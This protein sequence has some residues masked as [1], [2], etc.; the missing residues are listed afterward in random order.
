VAAALFAAGLAVLAPLVAPATAA[1]AR[2]PATPSAMF[3]KGVLTVHGTASSETI[4][5]SRRGRRATVRVDGRRVA[6]PRTYRNHL[7][8][9]IR[10]LGLAG[11][12]RI[13]I[14]SSRGKLPD[15]VLVGGKG[16]DVLTGGS[17]SDVLDGSQG[18][19]LLRPG[20]GGVKDVLDGG[21]GA[22]TFQ[23]DADLAGGAT[24]NEPDADGPDRLDLAGTAAPLTVYLGG[25][26]TQFVTSVYSITL[27][28]L[29][30][31]NLIGGSGDDHVVGSNR[32]NRI[33]GGPG[34]DIIRPTPMMA[35][36]SPG[37]VLV[38]DAG[39]D[40]FEFFVS[41]YDCGS[42]RIEDSAGSDTVSF[43]G[44]GGSLT[45][46]LDTTVV[47]TIAY[48][49]RLQLA[50]ESAVDN[51]VG[52]GVD[53]IT[54]NDLPNRLNGWYGDD[55]LTGKGGADTF[56]VGGPYPGLG[57]WG[58]D[59]VTDFAGGTDSVDLDSGMSVK[60]GFGTPTVTIWDGTTDEGTITASN[61]HL[62]AAQ[63]FA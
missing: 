21:L 44:S 28:K 22:D 55:T 30:V 63:D 1:P 9:E 40:T 51:V 14:D 24:I 18:D 52:G 6:L 53:D 45:T 16:D 3:A 12:D 7:C 19:D 62:W 2:G 15:I 31:E 23:I 35:L 48:D 29:G 4:S 36:D 25:N 26:R 8:H 39:D 5:I 27:P 47:Q 20:A 11:D 33:E 43:V 56:V 50:T 57:G 41:C 54:G 10:I 42:S 49:Y 13:T 38:G 59:T 60:S 46:R 32:P 58:D 17:R 61:G 37:N 34:N